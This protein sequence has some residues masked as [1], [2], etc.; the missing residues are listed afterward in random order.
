MND[1]NDYAP[2]LHHLYEI[3]DPDGPRFLLSYL[4]P[5]EAQTRGGLDDSAVLGSFRKGDDGQLDPATFE[6]N[7]TFVA[8]IIDYVNGE[9]LPTDDQPAS[10]MAGG[11]LML[12]DHRN[13]DEMPDPEA[14]DDE[15]LIGG[16][17]LDANGSVCAGS[18]R[19][20]QDH[21]LCHP[22]RGPSFLITSIHFYRWLRQQAGLSSEPAASDG[23]TG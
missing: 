15:D 7:P 22:E 20:N 6:V 9:L 21:Q 18:F 16:F 12:Y 3:D 13:R 23:C 17:Q 4:L 2:D 11:Q 19:Y 8:A 14:T 1:E 5:E 10:G